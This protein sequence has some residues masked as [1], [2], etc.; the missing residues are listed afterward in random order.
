MI[1][2][3]QLENNTISKEKLNLT[4]PFAGKDPVTKQYLENIEINGNPLTGDIT[5]S[6]VD[7]GLG[8]V[9][10]VE[11]INK[12]VSSLQRIAINQKL[13][14]GSITDFANTFDSTLDSFYL[15]DKDKQGLF[16]YDSTD[17]T[18]A[19]D[20][21]IYLVKAGKRYK[22]QIENTISVK[23]WNVKG[24]GITDDTVEF[25]K[26]VTYWA[27]YGGNLLIPYGLYRVDMPTLYSPGASPAIKVAS[28]I[29]KL[30]ITGSN[31]ILKTRKGI[32]A[33]GSILRNDISAFRLEGHSN[34]DL[35]INDLHILGSRDTE[36]DDYD[37]IAGNIYV[38]WS[39][40]TANNSFGFQLKDFNHVIINQSSVKDLHGR[41]IFGDGIK[42]FQV[43]DCVIDNISRSAI[44]TTNTTINLIATGNIITNIGIFKESFVINGVTYQFENDPSGRVWYTDVGD[45]VYHLGP[46]MQVTNNYFLNIN[47]IAICTDIKNLA[48]DSYLLASHNLIEH[49]HLRLRCSNPQ[50]SI[51]IEKAHSCDIVNN[52]IRYINR[53]PSETLAGYAIVCAVSTRLQCNFVIKGNEVYTENYNKNTLVGI[54]TINNS[55]SVIV[56]DNMVYGNYFACAYHSNVSNPDGIRHLEQ[57]IYDGNIFTN[58][59]DNNTASAVAY[60]SA[61]TD[62]GGIPWIK[63]YYFTNNIIS[64]VNK[65]RSNANPYASE[66]NIVKG[67]DFDSTPIDLRNYNYPEN[68][69]YIEDNKNVSR[70]IPKNGIAGEDNIMYIKNNVFLGELAL[71]TASGTQRIGGE[72]SNNIING[73]I[74]IRS[75]K[76][77]TIKDNTLI[78]DGIY[79]NNASISSFRCFITGNFTKLNTD[80][81]G[82][83]VINSN[84][85]TAQN[86]TIK[87][88]VFDIIDGA[89]NTTG[90]RFSTA[91]IKLN[92]NVDNNT[93]NGITVPLINTNT[94]LPIKTVLPFNIPSIAAGAT[95][96]TPGSTIIGAQMGQIIHVA[97]DIDLEGLDPIHAYISAPDLV[98]FVV[99]NPTGSAIDLPLGNV[100]ILIP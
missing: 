89:T 47:R 25:M 24:D 82:V 5:I 73:R 8:N 15:T 85:F 60:D 70:I 18:S 50:S 74:F 59:F 94:H 76:D 55:G 7:L 3:K 100:T 40:R 86:M 80:K 29:R 39:A 19:Q 48:T 49:D 53:A 63:K 78:G 9:D 22:R 38:Q 34:C 52:T 93:F 57:L 83:N 36:T 62:G 12:P 92:L 54:K 26:A 44:E 87:G 16:K 81:L 71:S 41:A 2:G 98:K 79:F 37:Y 68:N 65:T 42:K 58:L 96:V 43:T 77:L 20:G 91:G 72:V 66:L 23:W 32:A 28:G 17:T 35:T 95:Y 61:A 46:T 30:T 84:Q 56:K 69:L 51:W 67:N 11:D 31:A 45:G 1:K 88:N 10:N 27:T 21:V 97:M 14:Y 75:H 13:S 4:A 33:N 64:V 90:I 99:H 6:K